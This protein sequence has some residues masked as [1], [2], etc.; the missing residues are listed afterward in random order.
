MIT[1]TQHQLNVCIQALKLAEATEK[2]DSKF[3]SV[4]EDLLIKTEQVGA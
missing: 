3:G 1:V 4:L 2:N